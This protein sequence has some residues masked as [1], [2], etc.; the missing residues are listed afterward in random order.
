MDTGFNRRALLRWLSALPVCVLANLGAPAMADSPD[1]RRSALARRLLDVFS[2][3]ESAY[4]VGVAYF[5]VRPSE[6]DL[7]A[8][9]QRLLGSSNLDEALVDHDAGRWALKLAARSKRDFEQL[10]VVQVDGWVLSRTEARLCALA[11]LV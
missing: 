9:L 5:A 7:S 6:R 1:S 10:R 11:V 4:G 8:L 2:D 3:P